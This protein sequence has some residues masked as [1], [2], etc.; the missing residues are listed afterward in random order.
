MKDKIAMLERATEDAELQVKVFRDA[1]EEADRA[2]Q[3]AKNLYRNLPPNQQET[4]QVNETEI[5]ELLE[6]LVRAKNVYET[7]EARLATNQRYLT[8]MREKASK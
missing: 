7:A 2:L 6:T 1:V 3:E 5:P 8:I 4:L